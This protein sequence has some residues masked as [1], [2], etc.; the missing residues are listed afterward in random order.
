MEKNKIENLL[1][2]TILNLQSLIDVDNVIGKPIV[3]DAG[4][5][6]IP[7]SKV[8]FG[9][10][11]GGGEYGENLGNSTTEKSKD[12]DKE[13]EVKKSTAQNDE[14]PYAGGSGG[15]VII[16]PI[17]FL[18]CHN[19]IS[20]LIKIDKDTEDGKWTDLIDAAINLIKKQ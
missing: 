11:A 7:F 5:I 1:T 3:A 19:G 8:S 14:L 4:T 13:K 6:V 18:V 17:G 9:F 20:N 2:S 15:G 16:N 12:K 10:I